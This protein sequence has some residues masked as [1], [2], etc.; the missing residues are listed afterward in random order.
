MK[1][2]VFL[3]C[4]SLSL[5]LTVCADAF[6]DSLAV[7]LLAQIDTASLV[8]TEN[9]YVHAV[10]STF[11]NSEQQQVIVFLRSEE[12]VQ[13]MLDVY[14]PACRQNMTDSELAYLCRWYRASRIAQGKFKFDSLTL[15]Q[16]KNFQKCYS[17]SMANLQSYTR[18]RK[19]T[20]YIYVMRYPVKDYFRQDVE[21]LVNNHKDLF[22]NYCEQV[23]AELPKNVK[24]LTAEDCQS[25]VVRSFVARLAWEALFACF[26]NT[27]TEQ[28]LKFY[29]D[30][31]Q[32]APHHKFMQAC[33]YASGQK[34]LM[35]I[36]IVGAF[37]K[38]LMRYAPQTAKI[39]NDAFLQQQ[40][41][42]VQQ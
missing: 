40:N 26:Y 31:L 10:K 39:L 33:N 18:N 21:F 4:L 23:L 16:D 9:E 42:N 27:F 11:A 22:Y 14:E 17:V 15:A 1:R 12:F 34:G 29:L 24:G 38:Y 28:D 32:S 3:L 19:R 8:K 41:N 35:G 36:Q 2:T 30:G 6:R 25:P 13:C 37:V 5:H 7:M 20:D